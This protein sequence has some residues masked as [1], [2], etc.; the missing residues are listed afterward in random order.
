MEVVYQ[1][2]LVD[3]YEMLFTLNGVL[4]RLPD[5]IHK[6]LGFIGDLGRTHQTSLKLIVERSRILTKHIAQQHVVGIARDDRVMTG[7]IHW[8]G[9]ETV[10]EVRETESWSSVG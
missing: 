3:L 4:G 6:T 9:D 2:V 10:V 5:D 1:V 8:H 7:H